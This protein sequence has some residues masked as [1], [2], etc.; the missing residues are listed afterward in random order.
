MTLYPVDWLVIFLYGAGILTAALML[1]EKHLPRR[2]IS[3]PDVRC[4]GPSLAPPLFAANISAEHFVG[5]AGSGYVM[6]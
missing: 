2:D 3:W 4:D 6:R 1:G 5:L